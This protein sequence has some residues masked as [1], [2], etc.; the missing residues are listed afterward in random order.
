MALVKIIPQNELGDIMSEPSVELNSLIDIDAPS[1]HFLS[2][3][4]A[5]FFKT[6]LHGKP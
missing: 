5:C 2:R 1:S 4:F 6:I 3:S